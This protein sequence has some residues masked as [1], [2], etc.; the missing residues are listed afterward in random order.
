MKIVHVILLTIIELPVIGW[1]VWNYRVG[2]RLRA[3]FLQGEN[4]TDFAFLAQVGAFPEDAAFLL[5]VRRILACQCGIPPELIQSHHTMIDL[6]R[7]M[8]DGWELDFVFRL[9]RELGVKAPTGFILDRMVLSVPECFGPWAMLVASALREVS[10]N[11][12]R[13]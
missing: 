12:D 13:K 10:K 1:M 8:W 11:S 2:K 4:V 6:C 3:Q 7:L 9:E 5:A